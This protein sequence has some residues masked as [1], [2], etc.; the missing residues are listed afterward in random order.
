MDASRESLLDSQEI[1]PVN[2]KGN[3][4]WIFIGRTYGKAENFQ[5]LDHLIWRADP[6]EKTLMREIEGRRRRG[7]EKL[8]WL[9][10]ISDSMDMC[11]SKLWEIVKDREAWNAAVHG[12]AKTLAWLSNRTTTTEVSAQ[13][14]EWLLACSLRARARTTSLRDSSG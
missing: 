9:Y 11:L 2:P 14:T 7:W 4:H 10:G 12:V 8:R 3:Q 5:Y 6:L 1:K 13:G